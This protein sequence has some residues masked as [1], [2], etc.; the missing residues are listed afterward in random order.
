MTSVCLT[1]KL[2]IA[3]PRVP[4]ND[5][6]GIPQI[7]TW[8]MYFHINSQAIWLLARVSEDKR[9]QFSNDLGRLKLLEVT[10]FRVMCG[11][12]AEIIEMI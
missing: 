5:L 2:A 6:H 9:A 8:N 1:L 4:F 11:Y 12:V 3:Y 10:C 7:T